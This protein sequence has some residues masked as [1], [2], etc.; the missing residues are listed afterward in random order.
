MDMVEMVTKK[1]KIVGCINSFD[2]TPQ[3]KPQKLRIKTD[4]C[5]KDGRVSG[6]ITQLR[7]IQKRDGYAYQVLQTKPASG[8]STEEAVQMP[9]F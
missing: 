4:W 8:T 3:G 2:K 6:N 5:A 7:K 9:L 1:R